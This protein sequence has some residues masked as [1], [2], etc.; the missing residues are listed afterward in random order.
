MTDEFDLLGPLPESTTVLEASAGTG[1]TYAIVAM[2][3]RYVAAGVPVSALLMATF[4]NAASAELRDRTH[5]RLV[6][7]A[8]ALEDPERAAGSADP[9]I[10]ALARD[11]DPAAV[12]DRLTDA[13][14]DFDAATMAT[15]HT[16]CNRML[17][18][19]GFL[20]DRQQQFPIL[21]N[22]D[23]MVAELAR[24]A[25]L[26]RFAGDP[27]SAPP[28]EDVERIAIAAVRDTSARLAPTPDDSGDRDA[29]LRV[30]VAEHARKAATI[31][32]QLARVRTYS[33]LQDT[34]HR[35]VVDEHVGELARARIRA[36][37]SA[38]LV[39]EFQDTDPQQWD[40][41]R[42]C[43]HGHVPMILVGDPKQ[44]IYA[45]RGAEVLSY[46]GAART[47]GDRRRLTVNRRS[48][49]AV[50][51]G[52]QSL[53]HGAA[54]G[55]PDIRHL[56]V[57]AA[58]AGSRI[59]GAA[60]VRIRGFTASDFTVHT[61]DGTSPLVGPVRDRVIEDVA[62]DIAVTLGG[63]VTVVD[64]DG[65]A[66][67][68]EPGDVAV[69]LRANK[70]IAP[71]QRELAARG[72]ASVVTSGTSIFSTRAARDW[73]YVLSAIET[74]SRLPGLRLAALT[75]IIGATARR[76]HEEGD[77]GV[78]VLAGA[79]AD[80]ATV[81]VE[82]G[83]AAMAERL[84]TRFETAERLLALEHGERML[85]DVLQLA[86]L[87]NR[88]AAAGRSSLASLVEWL[89]D[90]IDDDSRWGG[91]G[92]DVRRLDRDTAAV[93]IMT[94]H[95][96]KGLEFPIVYIPFGWDGA[97][98]REPATFLFHDDDDV[99][100][101]D[102]GGRHARGRDRREARAR[103]ES[104]GEDLRLL[105]VAATRAR[106]QVVMW[107]APS[108]TTP[109]GALHRLLF[110]L[111]ERRSAMQSDDRSAIPDV[112][113]VPSDE[114]D[115][116]NVLRSAADGVSTVSVEPAGRHGRTMWRPAPSAEAAPPLAVSVFDRRIDTVWRRTS[117]SAIVAAAHA[118]AHT[119]G[120]AGVLAHGALAEGLVSDD[121]LR[122]DEPDD[123]GREPAT[124]EARSDTGTPSLMNGLPFGAAFGTLVHEVLEHVDTSAPDMA[125]HVVR[126]CSEG[127]AMRGADIDVDV[128]ARSL[129]GVLT[130]PLGFGDLWSIGPADRLAELDFEMPLS[131][132][133][134]GF[135]LD[136]VGDLLRRHLPADDPLAPYADRVRSVSQ[137]RFAGFLTGSIDSVLRIPGGRF[138][139][140][141]YKTN[142]IRPGDLTVEDF[143]RD[144]MAEEM[145][146]AHYPLQALLY[147]VA[148]HRYLR[149]RIPDYG[150]AERLGPVQYHFVRGMAGPSTPPGCGV[151]EWRV[152]PALVIEMS[153][154]LA[155]R[156]PEEE[157]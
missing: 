60:A 22:V 93:Q 150:A 49:E 89:G 132:R 74:P 83:F 126:K 88:E 3:V 50:V 86:E 84:Y 11:G 69:L 91:R 157:S 75:P 27:D 2:A 79:F 28:Y 147:S 120:P 113:P 124:P 133:R 142:R 96:S 55:H 128:L 107:W 38:V 40:I 1:K 36:Q 80:L 134:G 108:T 137:E 72:I 20:G 23:D 8:T 85:T 109:R 4:S 99:R 112:V 41:L 82:G 92:E 95:A 58:N 138:A 14:S 153:A 118:V 130:T 67:S 68:V 145:M 135:G 129:I 30:A 149:W 29:E 43:F 110:T 76:L 98:P 115:C 104:A 62:D 16:F 139:V 54:L 90:R 148:L 121:V 56:P 154:L 39:D 10:A 105:Y 116:V 140:V 61:K 25:Y 94:V 51:S 17:A 131:A 156:A 125:A 114:V 44:S 21:E 53:F 151:F 111:S 59:R 13:L 146:S 70:T 46:L 155:G 101:L 42:L 100:N 7:C 119:G 48:D 127:A 6:E 32:K 12:R 71:L 65:S 78:G 87:C 63:S 143:D 31:R 64:D 103:A 34:L 9:L 5:A 33:D 122:P 66:R 35:I 141:D 97:G 47:A 24:D 19:L 15:T 152:P 18:A 73:W 26:A 81:F 102:V 45:F 37:F 123:A 117:Y 52:L 106:S 77:A 136:E 57:V 144:S